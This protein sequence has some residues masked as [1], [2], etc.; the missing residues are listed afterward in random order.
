MK[1]RDVSYTSL[2][3]LELAKADGLITNGRVN[4]DSKNHVINGGMDTRDKK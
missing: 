3:H 1:V 2:E 4:K